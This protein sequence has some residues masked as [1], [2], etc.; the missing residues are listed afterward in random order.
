VNVVPQIVDQ[1]PIDRVEYYVDG[2]LDTIITQSPFEY[3]WVVTNFINGTTHSLFAR[4]YDI[5]Q[6]NSVS[7]NISVLIQN[8]DIIPPTVSIIYPAAGAII[9]AGEI[10]NIT[11]EAQDNI[12]IQRVEFYVDG[13]LLSTDT[14]PPYRYSWDTTTYGNGGLHTVFVKAYDFAGNNGSELITVTVNP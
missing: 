1:S 14:T 8:T 5:Y 6:N 2:I 12:G 10:V 13:D 11:A 3:W 7:G 9:T 4:A